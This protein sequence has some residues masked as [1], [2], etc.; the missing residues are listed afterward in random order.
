MSKTKE[1]NVPMSPKYM[2]IYLSAI[3][4]VRHIALLLLLPF[5]AFCES[6]FK[7]DKHHIL[8]VVSENDFYFEDFIRSDKYYT[9][10]HYLSYTSK[11]LDDSFL[12]K[13][14]LFSYFSRHSF[15]RLNVSLSQEIYTPANKSATKPSSDDMLYGAAVIVSFSSINRT[16]NFMEQLGI[17]MGL[18]GPLALGEQIQN[19]VHKLTDKN[20][21]RGWDTQIK[22]EFLLNLHYGMI[23]SVKLID[24]VA[25]ILPQGQIFLGNAYTAISAGARLRIGYGIKNDF[26]IQ[27][28]KSKMSQV[29]VDNG[30]KIYALAGVN[31]SLVGRDIFI[32]GNTFKG[33]K[34]H[35][36]LE[37][38]LY[39]YVL[40][41]A[42]GYKNISL[43]Y[44]FTRGSK[45][46]KEQDEFHS[47]GSLRLDMS[48]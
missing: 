41:V 20:P 25:D 22:N 15:A 27:K 44:L 12:N 46:F 8:S 7:K 10:G 4:R 43:S 16:K 36:N 23:Y 5:I 3:S 39:E 30:L 17:D 9:A 2:L 37:R 32:E 26:G 13:I 24:N 47:Y 18:A 11:E 19:S 6:D 29:M 21:S 33:V 48:F 31:G 42:I 40:G 14:K 45:K 38:T 28:Y 34:S 35:L 1:L